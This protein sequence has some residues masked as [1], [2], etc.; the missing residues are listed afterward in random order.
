MTQ[1]GIM[2]FIEY[3]TMLFG[4]LIYVLGTLKIWDKVS[5]LMMIGALIIVGIIIN[6]LVRR[7]G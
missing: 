6:Q 7:A 2:L 3:F 1:S 4:S 5:L